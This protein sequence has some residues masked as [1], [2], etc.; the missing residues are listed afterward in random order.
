MDEVVEPALGNAKHEFRRATGSDRE[1]TGMDFRHE[2]D[3]HGQSTFMNQA[4]TKPFVEHMLDRLEL[5]AIFNAESNRMRRLQE[6]L[7][8]V[9]ITGTLDESTPRSRSH[10]N[11]GH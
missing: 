7:E 9:A 2:L 8:R 4:T 6:L 1:N 10:G 5:A 11:D 3:V